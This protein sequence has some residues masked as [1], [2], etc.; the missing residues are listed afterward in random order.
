MTR[1]DPLLE[2]L[3]WIERTWVRMER[4]NPTQTINMPPGRPLAAPEGDSHPQ[5]D[6]FSL[7]APRRGSK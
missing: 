5:G 2:E 4:E 1:P 6:L 3:A 7:E